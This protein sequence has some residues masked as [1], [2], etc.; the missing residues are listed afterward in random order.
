[1]CTVLNVRVQE[2]VLS[3]K[4]VWRRMT[5]ITRQLKTPRQEYMMCLTQQKLSQKCYPSIIYLED[6]LKMEKNNKAQESVSAGTKHP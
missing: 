4:Q 5:R 6:N 3:H 2:G 1:V